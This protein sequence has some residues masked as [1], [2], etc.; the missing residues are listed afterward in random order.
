MQRDDISNKLLEIFTRVF[1]NQNIVITNDLTA[2]DVAGWDSLSHMVMIGE[3][4]KAFGVRFK[5]RELNGI[6]TVG[7][8]IDLIQTKI[9]A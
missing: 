3:V 7:L 2:A 5:L 8:F 1:K 9:P 4:E 6:K